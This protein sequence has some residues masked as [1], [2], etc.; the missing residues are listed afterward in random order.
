M[1]RTFRDNCDTN[2]VQQRSCEP[3]FPDVQM[4]FKTYFFIPF[5]RPCMHHNYG[6]ISGSHAC[7]DCV[8]HIILDAKLHTT[9]PG[10]Q[11]L[12]ATRFIVTFLHLRLCYENT[13][14]CF[15]KDAANLTTHAISACMVTC[16]DA[17]RLFVIVPIL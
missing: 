15:S 6:V 7:R 10:E 9:C 3:P 12:V 5:V 17:A 11:V 16:F 14:A 1:T 8:W 2:I 13:S 4:Q